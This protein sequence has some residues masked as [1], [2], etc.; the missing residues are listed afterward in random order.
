MKRKKGRGTYQQSKEFWCPQCGVQLDA[1]DLDPNYYLVTYPDMYGGPN[2]EKTPTGRW[3]VRLVRIHAKC[4]EQ[5]WAKKGNGKYNPKA[6]H[7]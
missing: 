7:P 6:P 2:G 4:R 1:E 5:V 3:W